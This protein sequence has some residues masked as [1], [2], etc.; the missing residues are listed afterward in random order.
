VREDPTVAVQAAN[1]FR[2]ARRRA[3]V[4][5]LLELIGARH[6]PLL[7][8]DEVRKRLRA[9]EGAERILVDV[10]LDSIVGS[11]GRT[12]DFTREFLPRT[13][14]D[15]QRW[16][17]VQVA[18][19]GQVGTPPVELY[20]LGDAYFVRDG[21]HRV[22]VARQ[23]GA[24]SIQAYV[25]PVHAR[26]PLS[27]DATPDDI[28]I[29]TE[30]ARFLEQTELDRR[31]PGSNLHATTA[32]AYAQLLE[33]IS[34]HRYYMGIDEARPV[35]YEEAVAHWFDHIYTP[36]VERIRQTGLMHG[37][38]GRSEAD[39]YLFM[40]E[41][42]G[43]L[44]R[45]LGLALPS[46]S[47]AVRVARQKPAG[48]VEALERHEPLLRG[49]LLLEGEGEAGEV[50]LR[51]ALRL[52]AAEGAKLYALRVTSRSRLRGA[53]RATEE[54]AVE[55]ARTQFETA[56]AAV[57]VSGQHIAVVGHVGQELHA[58][59]TW[60]ELVVVP[61]GTS[62]ALL[63]RSP[64][65]VLVAGVEVTDL[66]RPLVAYD[67][68]TRAE[69]ALYAGAYLA[70]RHGRDLRVLTVAADERQAAAILARAHAALAPHGVHASSAWR[71]GPVP[72]AIVDEVA[73]QE[74]DAL[75]MGAWRTSP[76][77]ES[78]LGGVMEP[79]L[80]GAQVPV[81]VT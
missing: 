78:I 5:D 42:R 8:Y 6:R 81:L 20:R 27:A 10:P 67:G 31:R 54:E 47:I 12:Q 25:T 73:Q 17:G 29:A 3:D 56:C 71:S 80:R 50:A 23:L 69:A 77:L 44:Q 57:G 26:V 61:R 15:L 63:R 32:G 62:S 1:D 16:V 40:S 53:Q 4:S 60:V 66:A 74:R 58:R 64:R 14:A 24:Q 68:G 55:A 35:P 39:L 52:A 2:R 34:V 65:P 45:E 76:W 48:A 9:V 59:A 51:Q 18:M 79:V 75:L 21:N 22:S 49:V 43:R 28:I 36:V 72:A 19:V 37:F 70:A 30:H 7:G 11:V 13:D 33:H 38:E 46:T 41:H